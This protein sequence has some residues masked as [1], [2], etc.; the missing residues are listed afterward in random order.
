MASSPFAKKYESF[1]K[2]DMEMLSFYEIINSQLLQ[3]IPSMKVLMGFLF[4]LSIRDNLHWVGIT[5]EYPIS[6]PRDLTAVYT[7]LS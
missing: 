4:I 5:H 3:L 7:V 2:K 6:I 1:W